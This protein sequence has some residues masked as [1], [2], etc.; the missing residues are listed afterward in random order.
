MPSTR[1]SYQGTA[2]R[3]EDCTDRSR[4][5]T[6]E[7]LN[8]A[9]YKKQI[10]PLWQAQGQDDSSTSRNSGLG[11]TMNFTTLQIS[12]EAGIATVTLNRPD[13]RNAISYELIDDLLGALDEVKT[14]SARV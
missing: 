10:R 6:W 9:W 12:F 3:K 8:E 7:D 2:A 4:N 13:K 14:S 5:P 11:L 1:E